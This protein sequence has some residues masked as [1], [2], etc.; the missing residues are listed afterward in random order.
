MTPKEERE[1]LAEHRNA[2]RNTVTG[3]PRIGW[4]IKSLRNM[5]GLED[6]DI[7]EICLSIPFVTE[8]DGVFT[9][10]EPEIVLQLDTFMLIKCVLDLRD[11]VLFLEKEVGRLT[12]E[13]DDC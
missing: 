2:I 5:V 10:T 9:Y 3:H 4:P 11:R 12:F 1:L 6:H 7:R 13:A 8:K